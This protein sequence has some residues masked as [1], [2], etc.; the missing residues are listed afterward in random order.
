MYTRPLDI[1]KKSTESPRSSCTP[2]TRYLNSRFKYNKEKKKREEE[3][4]VIGEKRVTFNRGER[5]ERNKLIY[6]QVYDEK[7]VLST[8]FFKSVF[9]YAFA[10]LVKRDLC[11]N[12][13]IL[14][15]NNIL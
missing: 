15:L 2:D 9:S 11:I 6:F 5:K 8:F 10:F 12:F 4:D 1:C 7:F 3:M 13:I 14:A